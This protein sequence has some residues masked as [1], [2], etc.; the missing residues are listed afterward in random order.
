MC[1][2]TTPDTLYFVEDRSWY[3]VFTMLRQVSN[4]SGRFPHHWDWY[5]NVAVGLFAF[6]CGEI[7]DGWLDASGEERV[8]IRSHGEDAYD[9]VDVE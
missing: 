6:G 5:N 2:K 3:R 1:P 4:F 8:V 9:G 7:L